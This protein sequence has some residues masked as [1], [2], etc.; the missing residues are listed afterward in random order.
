MINF[1]NF[2]DNNAIEDPLV[3]ISII[4]MFKKVGLQAYGA[5]VGQGE[6]VGCHSH[7]KGEE[8]YIILSGEGTIW[9]ADVIAGALKNKRLD[10]F[11]KGSVFCIYPDTAHQL[12]ATTDVEF[13]FLCPESHITH[14]R[15]L[16]DNIVGE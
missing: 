10:T 2:N 5:K 3:G 15:I 8:W 9:T 4:T 14:D 12:A 11:A 7:T 13:I 16:F 6:R 1:A